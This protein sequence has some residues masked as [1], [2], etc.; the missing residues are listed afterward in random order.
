MYKKYKL[1]LSTNGVSHGTPDGSTFG[2]LRDG[3][4]SYGDRL[5][6]EKVRRC[7]QETEE[8]CIDGER[9][10]SGQ[11]Q[12]EEEEEDTG[13]WRT[14]RV[15]VSSTFTDFHSERETLVKKVKLPHFSN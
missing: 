6:E 12:E 2:R 5:I 14:V 15:F 13:G 1:G 3:S 11:E 10:H 8:Q 4:G 7:W 9:G